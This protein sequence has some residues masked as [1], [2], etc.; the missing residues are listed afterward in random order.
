MPVVGLTGNYGMGKSTVARLFK[1]AGAIIL[2]LDD[3]V[4]KLLMK[5]HVISNIKE[6]FGNIVF[7][8]KNLVKSKLADIVFSDSEKRERLE[9]LLHPLVI[10][11]MHEF[12]KNA[13]PE[14][15]V[16]IEIPLLFEKGYKDEFDK[17][18][19]VY[20]DPEI[21][22]YR[23]EKKGVKRADAMKRL[24]AQMPVDEKIKLSDFVIR[25]NGTIEET[26]QQV[27]DIYKSLRS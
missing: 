26:R 21:A 2:D 12:I 18:I 15:I 27:L 25:N 13:K 9:A 5:E 14:D 7:D 8:G 6:I 23:L 19:T 16:I 22:I 20:A 17:T 24:Q 1:E 3:V 10:E 11:R 4:D